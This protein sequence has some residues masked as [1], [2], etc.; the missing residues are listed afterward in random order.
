[1][2]PMRTAVI[3]EGCRIPFLRSGTGYRDQRSYDLARLALKALLERTAWPPERIDRVILGTVISN[4]ATSNVAREAALAAGI[5]VAVPAHTVTQACVSSNQA[6]TSGADLIAAGRA[7]V[8]LAGGTESMSDIP[9]RFRKRFRDRLVAAQKAK[10]LTKRMKLF[11]SLR[12]SDWLPE[13]P[14]ITEFSTGRTMGEDC[15]RMAARYGVSRQE[16][17]AYALRSHQLADQ[18]WQSGHLGRETASV[19]VAPDFAPIER[20]N[21]IRADSSLEK[22]AALKPAFVRP[23]GTVTAG[24]ASF[25][26]DGASGVLMMAEEKA[27]AEGL[28]I[29]GRLRGYVY[30]AQDPKDDL[31]L[32]PSFAVPRLLRQCGVS[33]SDI[34]VFEFHE[35]FAGQ[36][37][38]TLN[39][40]ASKTFARERLAGDGP[41]GE[42]PR[43][44]LNC[45]G[46]SLAV[47]HPFGATGT[48][49]VTTA[50]NRLRCED[51]TLA[52]IAACA[53][54]A[55]GSAVLIERV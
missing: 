49:L 27:R 18:A 28:K 6:V 2:K 16:Q 50:C 19:A 20:D 24:N 11:L 37:L 40:L 5:P 34:D 53:A 48:R 17:D 33:L 31:L 1:M 44:K 52:L 46:G 15:D 35:A 29:K 13:V 26:T 47:G 8:V 25:L 7:D 30:T 41:V 45:W 21:G 36:V 38:A 3:V 32:G 4:L 14:S 55:I 22:L 12:P 51:G 54:G 10:S 23:H 9:I 39:C 42:V 43:E